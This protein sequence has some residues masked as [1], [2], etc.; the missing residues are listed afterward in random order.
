M[1]RNLLGCLLVWIAM[2][3][4]VMAADRVVR[5]PKVSDN[6]EYSVVR[7]DAYR[8]LITIKDRKEDEFPAKRGVIKNGFL[9]GL[10]AIPSG[11]A[12]SIGV[13]GPGVNGEYGPIDLGFLDVLK[14]SDL[15]GLNV[16]LNLLNCK[17]VKSLSRFDRLTELH[18]LV[19]EDCNDPRCLDGLKGLEVLELGFHERLNGIE[20]ASG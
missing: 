5:F 7:R 10:V 11:H 17:Q 13:V 3:S 18:S 20:S 8:S 14:D 19:A 4:A 6:A 1:Y 9:E 12:L 16:P 15:C 2:L